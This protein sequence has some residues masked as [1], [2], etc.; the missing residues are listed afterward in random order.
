MFLA[1]WL[2]SKAGYRHH[3]CDLVLTCYAAPK[4]RRIIEDHAY[5]AA[6]PQHAVIAPNPRWLDAFEPQ[7]WQRNLG[8]AERTSSLPPTRRQVCDH[9]QILRRPRQG[10]CQN[11]KP[12]L[13]R[14][15][16][17]RGHL[18]TVT[19]GVIPATFPLG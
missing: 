16:A 5:S 3:G 4:L 13:F 18:T 17:P 7:Q 14:A 19:T 10:E 11:G 15:G 12:Q 6:E 1:S 8:R 2:Q 9:V